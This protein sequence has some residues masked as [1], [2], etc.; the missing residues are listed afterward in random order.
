MNV[1]IRGY[2]RTFAVEE[3]RMRADKLSLLGQREEGALLHALLDEYAPTA[4][5]ALADE[6][7]DARKEAR[8]AQRELEEA[9]TRA[10]QA[11]ERE[12]FVQ[13]AAQEA[14][15]ALQKGLAYQYEKAEGHK[16]LAE[17][18]RAVGALSAVLK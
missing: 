17:F 10:T 4:Q 13:E 11:E 16:A 8:D 2:P 18:A 3:L 9:E 6:M 5:A 1:I 12:E 14:L 7:Q 15:E